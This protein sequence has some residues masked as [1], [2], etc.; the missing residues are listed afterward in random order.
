MK[1]LVFARISRIKGPE[2]KLLLG[3]AQRVVGEKKFF[4]G[5]VDDLLH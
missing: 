3:G 1:I 4:D 5:L 2:E